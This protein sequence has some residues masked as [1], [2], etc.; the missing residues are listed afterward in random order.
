M[1]QDWIG[2]AC[3]D[4]PDQND[5]WGKDGLVC[6]PAPFKAGSIK[7]H[8]CVVWNVPSDRELVKAS[9]AFPLTKAGDAL[10]NPWRQR[11]RKP[12]TF[13]NYVRGLARSEERRV[14]KECVRTVRS[15]WS[16]YHSQKKIKELQI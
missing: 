2:V 15:W 6:Y 7:L 14:G 16:P 4:L 13:G 12:A 5:C 8:P 9:T 1:A 3:S 10:Q 11:L